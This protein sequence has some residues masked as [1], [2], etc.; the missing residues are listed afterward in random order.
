MGQVDYREPNNEAIANLYRKTKRAEAKAAAGRSA[1]D[2]KDLRV[3]RP[4]PVTSP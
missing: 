2:P 1:V 4:L 3:M